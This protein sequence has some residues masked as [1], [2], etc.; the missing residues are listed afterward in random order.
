MAMCGAGLVANWSKS[1]V[2][3]A[4][5]VISPDTEISAELK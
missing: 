3:P 1:R 4:G 5:L 2:T